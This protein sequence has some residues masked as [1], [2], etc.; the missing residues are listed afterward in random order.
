MEW[1][2][3]CYLPIH[4]V[5]VVKDP[6]A[7]H[8]YV[9]STKDAIRDL[10]QGEWAELA[11]IL[12]T[13]QENTTS[14]AH[15]IQSKVN[16]RI[17][18]YVGQE[19]SKEGRDLADILEKN[20]YDVVIVNR[21]EPDAFDISFDGITFTDREAKKQI[22]GLLTQIELRKAWH[23]LFKNATPAEAIHILLREHFGMALWI[24]DVR[25][26]DF[27]DLLSEVTE[28]YEKTSFVK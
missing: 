20:G 26:R 27:C 3:V 9:L 21:E 4:N 18:L 24:T 14:C 23:L 22:K 19:K 13:K 11:S 6:N 1:R 28:G 2:F 15:I 16:P 10:T 5:S 7:K 25:V 17:G 8:Y 12:D